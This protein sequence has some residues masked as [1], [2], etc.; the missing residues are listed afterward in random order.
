MPSQDKK[1]PAAAALEGAIK[2]HTKSVPR[3]RRTPA[4]LQRLGL[5][6]PVTAADVKQAYLEKAKLA[7]PDHS[8]DADQ[9]KRV[10]EAFDEAIRFAERNGKRLPWIGLQMPIYVAQRA[11]VTMV[12]KWGGQVEVQSLDWLEETI[13]SDFAAIA[14]RLVEINLSNTPIGD[15][16]IQSLTD[17]S[18]GLQFLEVL[19]LAGTQVTDAGMLHLSRASN[20]RYID[21]RRTRTTRAM[22]KQL[23]GLPGMSRV[24]GAHGWRDWMPLG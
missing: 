6:L 13:G 18:E 11:I 7:H 16:E 10:Q 8:G 24:D 21:L 19:Q 4:F 17:E 22:R 12:E 20:L 14:D 3:G 1:P 23:A 9:F 5:S 2:R 15:E